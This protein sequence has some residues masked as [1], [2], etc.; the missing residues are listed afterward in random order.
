MTV[1][2]DFVKVGPDTVWPGCDTD[3]LENSLR[4][5]SDREIL[6]VAL[7][8]AS[9]VSAYRHLIYL[10]QK[11]RNKICMAIRDKRQTL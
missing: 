6:N 1:K 10:P 5:G 2:R 8:A 9:V 3:D 7:N 4:Y 11:K